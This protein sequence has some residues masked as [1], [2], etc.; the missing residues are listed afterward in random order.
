MKFKFFHHDLDL[1]GLQDP[2]DAAICNSIPLH[3]A[4]HPACCS[5]WAAQSWTS[6]LG[7]H[8]GLSSWYYLCLQPSPSFY[9]WLPLFIIWVSACSEHLPG[10][11]LKHPPQL[12]YFTWPSFIQS[13]FQH[14]KLSHL[15]THR[16]DQ[17]FLTRMWVSQE[18]DFFV[19]LVPSSVSW[20]SA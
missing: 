13:A 14:L 6:R 3:S 20:S 15:S 2:P 9:T 16:L 11:Q 19:R 10:F 17:H 12:L 4:T 18:Q 8:Q 5:T 1:E 7:L